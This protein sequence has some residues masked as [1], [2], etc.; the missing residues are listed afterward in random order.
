MVLNDVTQD[1]TAFINVLGNYESEN[2]YITSALKLINVYQHKIN[3]LADTFLRSSKDASNQNALI[4]GLRALEGS[5]S[6]QIANM[7]I[8]TRKCALLISEIEHTQFISQTVQDCTRS[9]CSTLNTLMSITDDYAA[10]KILGKNNT[11]TFFQLIDKLEDFKNIHTSIYNNHRFLTDT[12]RELLEILPSDSVNEDDITHL[13]IRSIKADSN[14]SS[15]ADDLKLLSDCLQNFERL[16]KCDNT[17][18]PTIFIRKIESG[19][20]KA[21][22]GGTQIDF[23]IFPDLIG[24]ITN[25]IKTWRITPSEIAKNEAEAEKIKAEA[26]KTKAETALIQA[27]TE[28]QY[29]QNEGSRTA[30]VKSQI[31]Y[32]CEK[33]GLDHD[34]PAHVEQIERFCHPL[35]AYIQHNPIGSFN[36]YH[37][38]ISKE[39]QLI[40]SQTTKLPK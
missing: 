7:S 39:I 35:V 34:N 26:E 9:F 2:S 23:S 38:D 6:E 22:F 13:D 36:G 20:L 5:F 17:L 11:A 25:A 24:S 33:L 15:F 32:L 27:Q 14:I 21:L 31:D 18:S 4:N 1:Y 8:G 28:S 40:E 10:N 12:E 16:I 37:Y 29:I 30:I 3:S 19:S